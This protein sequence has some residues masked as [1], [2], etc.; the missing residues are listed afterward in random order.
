M[1]RLVALQDV[2]R[3]AALV[4]H[5]GGVLAVY[6]YSNGYVYGSGVQTMSLYGIHICHKHVTLC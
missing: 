1:Y 5:V 2:R 3:E 6:T 4:T